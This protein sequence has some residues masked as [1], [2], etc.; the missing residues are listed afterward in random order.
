MTCKTISGVER[1]YGQ[2]CSLIDD[3]EGIPG[4]VL[5]NVASY[6]DNN[7]RQRG[8]KNSWWFLDNDR[9]SFSYCLSI[10]S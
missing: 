7:L 6:V 5:A 3:D 9:W 2:N 10:A 4:D 1:D 8:S